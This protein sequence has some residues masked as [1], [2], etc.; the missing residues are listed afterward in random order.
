MDFSWSTQQQ[1]LYDKV[2]A[3]ARSLACERHEQ[4]EFPT[5]LWRA[6]GDF[7]LFGLPIDKTYGAW[8][9]IF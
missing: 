1:D 3:F 5:E 6:I 9:A 2:F 4:F 8:V 7:G